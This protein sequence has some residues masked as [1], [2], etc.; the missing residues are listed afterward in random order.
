MWVKLT[1]AGAWAARSGE[2]NREVPHVDRWQERIA[3]D[4]RE[5]V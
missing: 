3:G 2:R 1:R 4:E 5:S